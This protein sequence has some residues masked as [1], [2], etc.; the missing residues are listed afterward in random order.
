MDKKSLVSLVRGGD[1]HT[2]I[3]RALELIKQDLSAI[4]DKKRILIKPNLLSVSNPEGNTDVQA[5]RSILEFL[6]RGFDNFYQKEVV[7]FEGS[8]GA[9]YK[10]SSTREVFSRFGYLELEKEY[11]NVRIECIEDFSEFI[12]LKIETLGG[13]EEIGVLRH[14]VEDFDY[15][16]SVNLPK[17]HNYAIVTL[18]IKNMVGVVRQ[19]D[20]SLI[21]GLRSPSSNHRTVFSY[22]PTWVISL[23][24]RYLSG[25]VNL[26][27][28]YLPSYRGGVRL[29]HRNIA[30]LAK[31]AWPDLVVLDGLYGMEGSGPGDGHLLRLDVAIA[32]TD[33]LKADA[34]AVRIMGLNPEDIGYLYYLGQEGFGDYSLEGLVGD[35]LE[36]KRFEMHPTYNIQRQ[37]K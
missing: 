14:A 8:A 13:T 16:I 26:A 28:G 30:A 17:T 24:R 7:I 2:N 1:R 35:R 34:L 3:S 18:G 25:M 10:G 27:I 6:K 37:W 9:F 31:V 12:P 32:S 19:G 33:A 22:V 5:I 20:K 23:A 15:K 4:K 11:S 29:I 21:H 36:V